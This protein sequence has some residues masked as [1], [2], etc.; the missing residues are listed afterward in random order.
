MIC[1]DKNLGSGISRNRGLD[2]ARGEYVMFLDA[3]DF[4]EPNMLEKS[5]EECKKNNLDVIHNG[6]YFYDQTSKI[7]YLVCSAP[8]SFASIRNQVT[9]GN[10]LCEKTM[11]MIVCPCANMVRRDFILKNGIRFQDIAN[12]NDA[13]FSKMCYLLAERIEITDKAYAHCRKNIDGQLS[14]KLKQ[15]PHNFSLTRRALAVE[16]NKNG[17]YEKI[18]RDLNTYWATGM[19]NYFYNLKDDEKYEVFE[20]VKNDVKELLEN[21]LESYLFSN[22]YLSNYL[23]DLL[24]WNK[25]VEIENPYEYCMNYEKDK[26]DEIKNYIEKNGFDVVVWGYSKY[27]RNIGKAL[28]S[29]DINVSAIVDINY[30][31]FKKLNIKSPSIISKKKCIVIVANTHTSY[32][33]LKEIRR[34]SKE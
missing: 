21:D 12:N 14:A 18:C 9:S 25:P 16:T 31:K 23:L 30:Q 34:I 3:D 32:G 7:E 1:N 20:V 27:G 5:Y 17:L 19:I 8:R 6:V 33:I 2:I 11:N 15:Y 10:E 24:K 22:T 13:Y 29:H 26:K 4:Y 28:R